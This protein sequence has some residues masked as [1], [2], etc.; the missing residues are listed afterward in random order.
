[1]PSQP[2]SIRARAL[3]AELRR[4]REQAG[5][6]GMDLARRTGWS[7]SK[8]SRLE[9]GDRGTTIADVAYVLGFYGAN[10]TET[11]RLLELL[12]D[13]P[14]G[15][16]ACPRPRA[17]QENQARSIQTYA[18]ALIPPLLR[19]EA[20]AAVLGQP[21][22]RPSPLRRAYPPTALFHLDESALRRTVGDAKVM[23]DQLRRLVSLGNWEHV[24]IRVVPL[25]AGA[26]PGLAGAFTLLHYGDD[27][28]VVHLPQET[29]DLYLESEED[30]A[31]YRRIL[32]DLDEISLCQNRSRDLITRM[33]HALS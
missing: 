8:I 9:T 23:N 30:L 3:G 16:W 31:T 22:E 33:A 13:A 32:T 11:T 5:Y 26:H 1:M 28:P 7:H 21:P 17:S 6:T 27:R 15:V 19:T 18:P 25:S 12:R 20:Y 14:E 2:P 29:Q 4:K 24:T 10:D